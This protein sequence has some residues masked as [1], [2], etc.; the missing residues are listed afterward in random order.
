MLDIFY[1][2][3]EGRCLISPCLKTGALR[4]LLV[5][6]NKK[7]VIYKYYISN[8]GWTG[9]EET[10]TMVC[11]HQIDNAKPVFPKNGRPYIRTKR[12]KKV[13]NNLSVKGNV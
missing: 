9:F 3:A 8:V 5:K 13:L 6:R 2:L 11:H 1:F 10:L 12:D 4:Q 7:G